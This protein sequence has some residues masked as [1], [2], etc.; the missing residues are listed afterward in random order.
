[1]DG[2]GYPDGFRGEAIPFLSRILAVAD[3]FEA[4][5]SP[6]PYRKAISWEDALREL[7]ANSG[8]QFDPIV[9]RAA[10]R[11]V[12]RATGKGSQRKAA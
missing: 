10:A 6:R 7:Q 12:E 11:V 1:M 2:C 8:T 4:M 3:A 9:V 5:T